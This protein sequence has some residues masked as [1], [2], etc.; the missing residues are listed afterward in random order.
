MTFRDAFIKLPNL[1]LTTSNKKVD[2]Q[3]EYYKLVMHEMAHVIRMYIQTNEIVVKPS[4]GQGYYADIPWICLLSSNTSISPSAQKGLYIVILFN[5]NGNELYI[6]LNQGIT[7]FMNMG[8]KKKEMESR[9]REVV[10]YFQKE[11][12]NDIFTKYGYTNELIYLGDNLRDLAKG[13]TLTNIVSKKFTIDDFDEKEFYFCLSG[14]VQ[15]YLDII[16]YIGT[17]SYDDVLAL[18]QPH[19][20]F[21]NV[22]DALEHINEILK[23]EYFESRELAKT[24]IPVKKGMKRVERFSQISQGRI[25]KKVDYI[26]QAKEQHGVGLKGEQLALQIEKERLLSLGIDPDLYLKHLSIISDSYGYDIQSVDLRNGKLVDI[27]IEVKTTKDIKDTAFFI[28]KKELDVSV[29]K[30]DQ[31]R[32]FRIYDITSLYPKY[33][34]ADGPITENFNINP[35]TYSAIYKFEVNE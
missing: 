18:L 10:Q 27:F 2:S 19:N 12:S 17:K 32:I 8:L 1:K 13:Y 3:S 35:V 33:Y 5:K 28:S 15:E 23:E 4:V 16:E 22:D 26:K 25:Y 6:S 9:V 7:N 34:F 14:I 21:E 31:Y 20:N 30:H 24:P 29:E 11:L